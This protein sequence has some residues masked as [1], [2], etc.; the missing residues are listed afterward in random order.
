MFKYIFSNIYI[1]KYTY[2]YKVYKVCILYIENTKFCQSYHF[3]TVALLTLYT[4][5][6]TVCSNLHLLTEKNV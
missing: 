6:C 4:T 1:Y 2:I 3:P 5:P